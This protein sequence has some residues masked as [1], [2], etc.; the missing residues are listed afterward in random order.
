VYLLITKSL[1][2]AFKILRDLYCSNVLYDAWRSAGHDPR[3]NNPV[4]R[5][6][7]GIKLIL[8]GGA[9]GADMSVAALEGRK[10]ETYYGPSRPLKVS[11]DTLSWLEL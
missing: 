11:R 3:L 5:G 9:V 1:A 2:N 8:G 6:M 7:E 10:F 4:R